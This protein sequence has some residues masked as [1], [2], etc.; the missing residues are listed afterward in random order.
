MSLRP[1]M[2][3]APGMKTISAEIVALKSQYNVSIFFLV[4][5]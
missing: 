5:S 1:D 2:T 3:F 4:V